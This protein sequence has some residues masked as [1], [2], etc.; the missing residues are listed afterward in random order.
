VPRPAIPLHPPCQSRLASVL[1]RRDD[2]NW[3]GR[4]DLRRLK[5]G[6]LDILNTIQNTIP[7]GVPS[8]SRAQPAP[9]GVGRAE[10]QGMSPIAKA[11]LGLLAVYAAKNLR[12]AG[13]EAAPQPSGRPGGGT[14]TAD[15]PGGLGGAL[16]GGSIGSSPSS[17]DAGGGF[18]LPG[19]LGDLLK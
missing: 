11:L 8:D 13:P 7:G 10:S 12:R 16:G 14:V 1:P 18:G 15:A 6:L 4:V 19:G 3:A 5:M 2:L 17:S 9:G